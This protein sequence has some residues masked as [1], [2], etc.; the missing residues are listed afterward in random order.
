MG[1][2]PKTLQNMLEMKPMRNKVK[3]IEKIISG[4]K[5]KRY[6]FFKISGPKI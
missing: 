3:F 2:L 5:I 6:C 4:K 1:E